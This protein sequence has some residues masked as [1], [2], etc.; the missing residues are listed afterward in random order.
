MTHGMQQE[1]CY[2]PLPGTGTQRERVRS[3]ARLRDEPV[4]EHLKVIVPDPL[5]DLSCHRPD[6][7]SPT[8]VRYPT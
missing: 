3:G 2:I 4:D 7:R 5:G 8:P 6:L 1:E